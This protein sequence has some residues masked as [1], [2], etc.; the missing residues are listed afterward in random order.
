MEKLY[1]QTKTRDYVP[2]VAVGRCLSLGQ[3]P[4]GAQHKESGISNVVSSHFVHFGTIL[5]RNQARRVSYSH[6]RFLPLV[7]LIVPYTSNNKHRMKI[8][9]KPNKIFNRPIYNSLSLSLCLS[10]FALSTC[11]NGIFLFQGSYLSPNSPTMVERAVSKIRANRDE[12]R[13][14]TRCSI[15]DYQAELNPRGG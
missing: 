7:Q 1:Q 3:P 5:A 2:K 6:S 12:L 4:Q 15:D 11:G 13:E 8:K 9:T 10:P 14:N